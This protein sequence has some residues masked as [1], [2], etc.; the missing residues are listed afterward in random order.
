MRSYV[1]STIQTCIFVKNSLYY[2]MYVRPVGKV[3]SMFY[4]YIT[5]FL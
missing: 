5:V 2:Q 4:W 3:N 1:L